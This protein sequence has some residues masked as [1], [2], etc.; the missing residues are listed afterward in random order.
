M[1]GLQ[2]KRRAPHSRRLPGATAE[3]LALRH[4]LLAILLAAAI[5][6]PVLGAIWS[7]LP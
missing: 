1:S 5:V 4:I 2:R 3:P 7:Q 6:V